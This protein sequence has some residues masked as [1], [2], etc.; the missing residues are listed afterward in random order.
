M[1]HVFDSPEVLHETTEVESLSI[2]QQKEKNRLETKIEHWVKRGKGRLV[3][4]IGAFGSGKSTVLKKLDGDYEPLHFD[5]WR[6]A[7]REQI[8]AG[9]VI[10]TISYLEGTDKT[11]I[12]REIK[13]ETAQ[14]RWLDKNRG[15]AIAYVL[16][17]WLTVSWLLW[18]ALFENQNQI[19]LLFKAILKYSISIPFVLLAFIGITSITR[20]KQPLEQV[21]ELENRLNQALERYDMPLIVIVE[22]VDRAG[23]E[24]LVF[25]ETLR[26]FIEK[27]KERQ[28]IVIAPQDNTFLD[29]LSTDR[30][31]N[32]ERSLKIYDSILYYP[33]SSLRTDN[34]KKIIQ[35]AKIKGEYVDAMNAAI[36]EIVPRYP[37]Q[38]TT[39]LFKL[40]LRQVDEFV[41]TYP[42]ANP[43]I[44]FI[45]MSAK[46]MYY[47]TQNGKELVLQRLKRRTLHLNDS[48]PG[49]GREVAPFVKALNH[50]VVPSFT[51]TTFQLE[52]TEITE[53]E[54]QHTLYTNGRGVTITL[55]NKYKQI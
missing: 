20:K 18:V 48:S 55:D 44:V 21:F 23:E 51:G 34:A 43:A 1:S 35:S 13:G 32:F 8:W 42:S 53:G 33:A 26:N 9:F 46:L 3:A 14:E 16:L 10:E 31:Q 49:L 2:R 4:Y 28:L 17:G 7:N 39:R 29:I 40:I 6:Y 19:A 30:L 45:L 11:Q 37:R 50:V 5:I 38:L 27:H 25:M 36:M 41:D 12:T 15:R 22:D 24:G 52:Y 54:F 47:P